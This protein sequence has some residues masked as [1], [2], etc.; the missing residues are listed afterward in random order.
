MGPSNIVIP[1]FNTLGEMC[2]KWGEFTMSGVILNDQMDQKYAGGKYATNEGE[3]NYMIDILLNG[4]DRSLI[5]Q[6]EAM[7]QMGRI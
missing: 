2:H 6:K 4:L 3:Y 1:I 5:H 7:P